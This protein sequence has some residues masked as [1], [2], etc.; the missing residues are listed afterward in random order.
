MPES[1]A[2]LQELDERGLGHYVLSNMS[3]G[4]WDF[5]KPRHGFWGRFDGI[6][7][8]AHVKLVKPQREIY[9][10]LL[11]T[12]SLDPETTVFMDDRPENVE[13][14]RAAGIAAFVFT[15]AADARERLFGGTW[16]P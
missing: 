10:H 13:G 4:T 6:V 3:T 7:I 9:D 12:W 2:L 11:K 14:A 16:R 15:S 8:S 5:L 1:L